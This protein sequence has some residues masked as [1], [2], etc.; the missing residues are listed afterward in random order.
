MKKILTLLIAAALAASM[1]TTAFAA[2]EAPEEDTVPITTA[3]GSVLITVNTEGNGQVAFSDHD[4]VPEFDDEKP[5]QSLYV[6]ADVGTTIRIGAKA[7][8][9]W[10]FVYWKNTD[11]DEFFS[12]SPVVPLD[13][14]ESL[15]LTAVFADA[16]LVTIS[17]NTA[18]EG[19][20][21]VSE[22]GSEPVFSDEH[23][24]QSLALSAAVGDT[25]ILGAKA[26]E[27]RE[28]K[29]WMN[30]D[31]D[32]TYSTEETITITVSEALNLTAI[33]EEKAEPI[34][35]EHTTIDYGKGGDGF[36]IRTTSKS[37]TVAVRIDGGLAATDE[38]E[39]LT[40]ENGAVTFSKEL[41]DK[42]LK[43]GENHLNLVFSDGELEIA[44]HYTGES[45]AV[46]PADN[47]PKTG[48]TSAAIAV[49]AALVASLSA[50]LFLAVKRRK[51]EQ[52]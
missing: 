14:T 2:Q 28:F 41:A 31:T 10:K 43:D 46:K 35:A 50:A 20:I 51:G 8:E 38:T 37:D 16:S 22:D 21:A 52:E 44:V 33:F 30:S 12:M 9:G 45:S 40:L 26:D 36:V 6:N 24:K 47:T 32:E 48:D 1:A 17:A 15:D 5:K 18:G 29:G 27:G 3:N 11:T 34:L 19:Q 23:P 4:S 39:G 49:S 42:L 13:V 25:V 7:S